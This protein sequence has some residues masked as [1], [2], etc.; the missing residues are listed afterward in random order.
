M[1]K[2]HTEFLGYD[3]STV[4]APQTRQ[5]QALLAY[6]S[7]RSKPGKPLSRSSLIP[8]DIVSCLPGVFIAEPAGST[9]CFRLVGS[10]VEA[11][12]RRVATGKTLPEVYGE[13]FGEAARQMYLSVIE[14]GTPLCIQ[15]NFIG[16]GLEHM[17]VEVLLLPISFDN[18]SMGILGG[19]F[20]TAP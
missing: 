11:R 20:D 19:L 10:D 7:A 18:G 4:P 1:L 13:K 12:M 8:S 15:G 14:D 16:D 6:W 5:N 3:S 2:E 17:R 9:F